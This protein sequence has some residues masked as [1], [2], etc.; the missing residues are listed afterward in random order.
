MKKII[1]ICAVMLACLSTS[2]SY[3]E[4]RLNESESQTETKVPAN[5]SL[6]I[7]E[8]LAVS[9]TLAFGTSIP[10]FR[11]MMDETDNHN[12]AITG[13]SSGCSFRETLYKGSYWTEIQN[14][15]EQRQNPRLLGD[16]DFNSDGV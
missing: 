4:S 8:Q 13:V 14:I 10:I 6:V 16:F 11:F 3:S 2:F 15:I 7:A 5:R 12:I 9:G 1:M